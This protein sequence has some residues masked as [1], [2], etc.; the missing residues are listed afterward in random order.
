MA[1][2]KFNSV[3]EKSQPINLEIFLKPHSLL[4]SN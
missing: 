1:N 3:F 2:E 4:Y